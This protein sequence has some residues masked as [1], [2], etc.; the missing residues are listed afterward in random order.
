M[1]NDAVG[2]LE[3][4]LSQTKELRTD[5]KLI[6][7]HTLIFL[8]IVDEEE[9]NYLQNLI[10]VTNTLFEWYPLNGEACEYAMVEMMKSVAIKRVNVENANAFIAFFEELPRFYEVLSYEKIITL[11]ELINQTLAQYK[12]QENEIF[13][14]SEVKNKIILLN[15]FLDMEDLYYKSIDKKC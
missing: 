9:D 13:D 3:I 4:S 1:W 6:N 12:P 2:D 7:F 15:Y 8:A 14:N 10:N 5:K 11:K